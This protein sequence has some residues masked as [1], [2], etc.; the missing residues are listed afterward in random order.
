MKVAMIFIL[1]AG[2]FVAGPVLHADTVYFL[3]F[4]RPDQKNDLTSFVLP[5]TRPEDIE[6]ARRIA[7]GEFD[8]TCCHMPIPVVR[9]ARGRDGINRNLLAVGAPQWSWH[10]AE[11]L[12][13]TDGVGGISAG[14]PIRVEQQMDFFLKNR[15]PKDLGVVAFL[16]HQPR[17]ELSPATFLN[18]DVSEDGLIFRWAGLRNYVYFLEYTDSLASPDWMPVPGVDWPINTTQVTVSRPEK[19]FFYRLRLKWSPHEAAP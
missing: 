12:N 13:W 9:I 6:H 10:V 15:R 2:M 18:V 11:F 17:L 3:C 16:D 19:E 7:S 8:G 1:S 5:L 4:E 14:S